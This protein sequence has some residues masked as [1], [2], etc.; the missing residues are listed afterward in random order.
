MFTDGVT[1]TR[2]SFLRPVFFAIVFAVQFTTGCSSLDTLLTGIGYRHHNEFDRLVEEAT[3][4][5]Q[6]TAPGYTSNQANRL[7]EAVHELNFAGLIGL[8]A[9][10]SFAEP[11]GAGVFEDVASSL[12]REF[13][14]H[15]S[16]DRQRI[17]VLV[18]H[19]FQKLKRPSD[20]EMD[21][22]VRQKI[23]EAGLNHLSDRAMVPHASTE[24]IADMIRLLETGAF[25]GD[26]SDVTQAVYGGIHGIPDDA[27]GMLRDPGL[28]HWPA[29]TL[30]ALCRDAR[31]SSAATGP[32]PVLQETLREFHELSPVGRTAALLRGVLA[33]EN[34]SVR[35]A[36]ILY[37]RS[38]G[39]SEID[40]DA[41]D[42]VVT[43]LD[44]AHPDLRPLLLEA[45][46][47]LKTRYGPGQASIAVRR[48]R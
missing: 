45:A 19:A 39:V 22:A 5:L 11:T 46:D 13:G 16:I 42:R 12:H 1:Q 28:I 25:L 14:D 18:R 48:L 33:R 8:F 47:R 32:T 38:H 27:L 10:K 6:T 40:D 21:P 23:L 29:N 37:A 7:A 17:T 24:E 36:L 41:I 30:R 3:Y 31:S 34:R 9:G 15:P 44:P 43:A 26:A 4:A 2:M 20:I 35:L